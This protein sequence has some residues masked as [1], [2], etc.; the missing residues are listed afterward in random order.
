MPE[1]QR[2]LQDPTAED[3]WRNVVGTL[4]AIGTA[5]AKDV[6]IADV[7]YVLLDLHSR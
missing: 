3:T 5:R 4:G 6:L 2:L 7:I 1:L